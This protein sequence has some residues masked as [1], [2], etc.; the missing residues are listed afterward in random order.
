[1]KK[2]GKKYT[3]DQ[4]KN[5][6]NQLRRKWKDF[7]NLIKMEISLG[8]NSTNGQIIATDDEWKK[9]CEVCLIQF[10]VFMVYYC[11][12]LLQYTNN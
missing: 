6:F 4:F 3:K 10:Y 7:T 2:I 12:I 5:K 8:Y 9:L 11:V 1:M